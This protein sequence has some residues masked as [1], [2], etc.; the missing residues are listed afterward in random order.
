MTLITKDGKRVAKG[1]KINNNL[2]KMDLKPQKTNKIC[3]N[4]VGNNSSQSYITVEP[5]QSW[6]TLHT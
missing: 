2:Y 1:K 4:N 6:E 3:S 5:A